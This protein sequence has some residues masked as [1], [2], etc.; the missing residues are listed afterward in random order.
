MN[1]W[2]RINFR[3]L[4]K[5]APFLIAKNGIQSI[6]VLAVS[7]VAANYLAP[8]VYGSYKYIL[9]LIAIAGI[10]SLTGS[11]E[12]LLRQTAKDGGAAV[13]YLIRKSFFYQLFPSLI[14]VGISGYYF[15][16][17]NQIFA[18]SCLIA[19]ILFPFYK[20]ALL[21][22]S[23]LNGTQRFKELALSG[24]ITSIFT[25]SV[26]GITMYAYNSPLLLVAAYVTTHTLVSVVLF[27]II[28]KR[29]ISTLQHTEDPAALNYSGHLSALNILSKTA[30]HADNLIAFQLLG[31]AQLAVYSFA[32]TPVAQLVGYNKLLSS[33]V[34]PKFSKYTKLQIQNNLLP[35][36]LILFSVGLVLSIG[37]SLLAPFIFSLLFPAY[38]EAVIYTQILSLSLLTFPALLYKEAFLALEMKKALYITQITIPFTKITLLAVLGTLF[39]ILGIVSATVATRWSGLLLS[40]LLFHGRSK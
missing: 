36:I 24:I 21:Y 17:D 38:M 32:K 10:F 6:A 14:L 28:Y 3:Y 5:N 2:Q 39:G 33:L 35:K 37:Y 13:K 9:S 27:L 26:I 29:H 11:G 7:I 4:I 18:L 12:V 20:T 15:I 30:N 31:P 40:A 19:A 1:G 22:Q 25:A 16:L 23:F 34:A 8:E